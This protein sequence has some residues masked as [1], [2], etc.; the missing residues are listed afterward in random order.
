MFIPY[1]MSF[2]HR[3]VRY[4]NDKRLFLSA[5]PTNLADPTVFVLLLLQQNFGRHSPHVVRA[6]DVGASVRA[7]LTPGIACTPT[8]TQMT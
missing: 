3:M 6:A 7:G 5:L 2:A 4:H 1:V 8:G